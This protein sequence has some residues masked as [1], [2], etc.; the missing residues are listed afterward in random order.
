MTP[1]NAKPRRYAE[2]TKV[3]VDA[4]RSEL[5]S[6]LKRHGATSFGVYN[7]PAKWTVMFQIAGRYVKHVIAIPKQTRNGPDPEREVRRKWRALVLITKA[8]LELVAGGDSTVEREF[9]AD[10]VLAEGLTV[11]EAASKAIAESY[12]SGVTPR[13]LGAGGP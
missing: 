8:K 13:L 12:Q 11:Y 3:G 2:G 5:E 7:E 10:T 9:L 4:S 1:R 6:L